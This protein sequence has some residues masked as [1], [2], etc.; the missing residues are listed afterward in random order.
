METVTKYSVILPVRNGGE[1]V[2]ECVRSILSQ[3]F[4]RFHLHVLDNNSNDGTTE[5]IAS[6]RDERIILIR[7]ERSLTIEENWARITTIQKNE[8][9][10]LIGHD[11]LLEPHYL[12]TMDKLVQANPDASLFQ[13]HFTYIDAQGA[14][15][16]RCKPMPGRM[17]SRDMLGFLLC[18]M[19]DTMGTGFMMRAK[20]Y[21]ATGGIPMYPNL[22]FAD[23]EL[24]HKLSKLSF[25]A[26]SNEECFSFRLHQSTTTTSSDLNFNAAFA[27]F[28]EYL[29]IEEREPESRQVIERYGLDFIDFYTKAQAHRLLRT[30][31]SKR[32]GKSVKEIAADGKKY[33]DILVPGNAYDPYNN[34]SLQLAAW[35]D[36]NPVTRAMFLGFKKIYSKPVYS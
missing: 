4:T 8:F 26:I 19:I 15:I 17:S 13:S 14:V 25:L 10:T 23:F 34:F 3:D 30:P 12:S 1:Y 29:L 21:D 28:I 20:H 27:R 11:D 36:S 18:R 5:W 2:K 9:I 31:S 7:S 22:L 24:W 32:G 16:R 33:A 35:I 6:L